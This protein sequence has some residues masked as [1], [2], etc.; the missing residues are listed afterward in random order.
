M[1]I[2]FISSLCVP[3]DAIS[4]IV[5]QS[6]NW[7][8]AAGHETL[9]FSH[10]CEFKD[11]EAVAVQAAGEVATH[12]FYRSADVVL[13][14]MGIYYSLFGAVVA[15]PAGAR[16]L[17]RFHNV[18]PRSLMPSWQHDVIDKSIAQLS[19]LRFA[20]SVL[21]VSQ[22]NLDELRKLR[23]ETP[24][25]VR[26]LP[27]TIDLNPPLS[28]HSVDDDVLRI[29]FV[30]RFVRSKG[31]TELLSALDKAVPNI[32]QDRVELDMIGNA[33]FSDPELLAEV[34]Q[35]CADLQRRSA[36]RLVARVHGSAPDAFR[37]EMLRRA[38]LF[39]LPTYHEGF[40]VPVLE[41][42]A[43]GCDVVAYD[44]SNLPHIL[45]G[46]GT[47]VPTGDVGAL[48]DAIHSRAA[49]HADPAWMKE[50]YP[51]LADAARGH[52]RRFEPEP[53]RDLFLRDLEGDD[54]PRASDR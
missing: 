14:D 1:R 44:N 2:A 17:V 25:V 18:T 24:A 29:A 51:A 34:K 32:T 10:G 47:L 42:L 7:A 49:L 26:D 41:A 19:L 21:C 12:P 36:G 40:C 5:R 8:A 38:D 4:G 11:L 31:P 28:K 53:I 16:R 30:G 46:L 23:V 6:I 43:S 20:H 13:F 3:F 22:Y 52:L 48:A 50:G 45:G 33:E 35:R 39:V 54:L 15:A 37:D 9:L 27:V